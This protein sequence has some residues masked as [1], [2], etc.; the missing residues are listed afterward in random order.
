[1][2]KLQK[3]QTILEFVNVKIAIYKPEGLT[4][5]PPQVANYVIRKIL[6]PNHL[7]AIEK[8]I[9]TRSYLFNNFVEIIDGVSLSVYNNAI[10]A[11]IGR[12]GSGKS[13]LL[14]SI[15]GLFKEELHPKTKLIME[16]KIIFENKNLLLVKEK[17][18]EQ[19]RR[20]IAYI[21]QNPLAFPGSIL[22]NMLLAIEYWNPGSSR[23]RNLENVEL[24][25]SQVRLWNEVK[26]RLNHDA[27]ELSTGQLQRLCIAR[28]ISLS[29]DV[30][31][32][33][34]P[35]A[36]IDPPSTLI[37]EDFFREISKTRTVLIVT[38]NLKQA[39]RI[40]DEVVYFDNGQIVEKANPENLFSTPIQDATKSFVK[41]N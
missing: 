32:F 6:N 11:I 12:S 20:Q 23:K 1:M 40:A 27:R 33:D 7:K 31:L 17:S 34:E 30:L 15:I 4:L 5:L 16:G 35:C 22:D 25:L 37:L 21:S 24:Y 29:P 18:F 9:T 41:G 14:K 3:R 8:R 2:D 10:T 26:D 13:V 36:N 28:A 38:H 19:I 39:Q